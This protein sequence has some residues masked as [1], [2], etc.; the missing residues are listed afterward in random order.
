MLIPDFYISLS[1]RDYARFISTLSWF[2]MYCVGNMGTNK[3]DYV[4]GFNSLKQLYD[5]LFYYEEEQPYWAKISASALL[6][7]IQKILDMK[8][9]TDERIAEI[10]NLLYDFETNSIS[11][12]EL[13]Y[14]EYQ[15]SKIME[16]CYPKKLYETVCDLM[17]HREYESAILAAFKFL[18][19]HLQTLLNVDGN[20][21]YGED[22]INY[23]FSPNSGVLQLQ[24]HPN[25]QIGIRNFFSGANAIFR[26][27]SAHRFVEYNRT[28]AEAIVAMVAMMA[29]LASRIKE[30]MKS[31]KK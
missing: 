2:R 10:S 30:N 20:R 7:K 14:F 29:N 24:G 26:N 21:Y 17:N 11:D 1:S 19:S 12:F 8:H 18:D 28:T 31:G 13:K 23:V 6:E 9:L 4:S 5:D 15:T 25:E 16:E 3:N 22:L 27:P